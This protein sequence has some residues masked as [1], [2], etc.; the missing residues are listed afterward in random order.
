MTVIADVFSEIAAPKKKVRLMSKKPCFRGL[1][2][3]QM[4]NGSTLCCNLDAS[5]FKIFINHFE[6]SCIGE[7]LF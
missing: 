7:S 5:T 1:L 4:A 6:V 3:K 2:D